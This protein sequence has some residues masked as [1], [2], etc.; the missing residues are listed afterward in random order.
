MNKDEENKNKK[1]REMIKD[2]NNNDTSSHSSRIS[3]ESA[4]EYTPMDGHTHYKQ[5]RPAN[6]WG[7]KVGRDYTLANTN[8]RMRF[9]ANLRMAMPARREYGLYRTFDPKPSVYYR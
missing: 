4:S 6:V 7:P 1:G 3:I 2:N 5:G 9:D 8:N